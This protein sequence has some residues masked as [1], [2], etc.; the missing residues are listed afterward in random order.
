MEGMVMHSPF[1][2]CYRGR[3][4]LVTG[5]T[6]F[7]G[8]WL[9][10]WLKILGARV[11]GFSLPPARGK[12]S[13]FEAARVGHNMVSI[14]GDVRDFSSLGAAFKA[15]APEIVFH[16]AAQPLVRRSYVEPLETYATNIMGT[17]HVLEA[18]RQTS[19]VRVVVIITS[20]KCYENREWLYGY[21]ENDPLGGDDPYS[22]SKGAAELITASYRHAFFHP[23]RLEDHG[24]SVASVR[25]GN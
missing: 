25:A 11:I 3:S 6:G 9:T 15:H 20:D 14:I 5:H 23:E 8:G 1:A 24:V 13:L 10:T 12:P 2:S 22:A 21:R 17:V 7:K 19:S 18:V 16:M 4:V